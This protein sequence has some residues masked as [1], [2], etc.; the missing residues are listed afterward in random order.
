MSY[1]D[2]YEGYFESVEERLSLIADASCRGD[3]SRDVDI[4]SISDLTGIN[5]KPI[6]E[7]QKSSKLPSTSCF[8]ICHY[9]PYIVDSIITADGAVVERHR[10]FFKIRMSLLTWS[11]EWKHIDIFPFG[12][13]M[14]DRKINNS[15]TV[16]W[17]TGR[18][19]NIINQTINLKSGIPYIQVPIHVS[20]V[21]SSRA[22]LKVE[23]TITF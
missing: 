20:S 10:N 9:K 3:R 13:S 19:K 12:D 18:N 8:A 23:L 6:M 21:Y 15:A 17:E 16:C 1:N 11:K 2:Y 22:P 14:P 4:A 7:E 5:I